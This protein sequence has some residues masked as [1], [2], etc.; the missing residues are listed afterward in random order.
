MLTSILPQPTQLI[1]GFSTMADGGMSLNGGF[2]N[3]QRYLAG[4]GLPPSQTV[5]AGLCHGDRI[6]V[7]SA[8]DGGQVM[9]EADGLITTDS[10][11]GL[12]MTAAD[13]LLVYL[14]DERTSR[15][16]LIHAGRRGLARD[17]LTKT[18]RQCRSLGS[19]LG[20]LHFSISP[21]ICQT[22]YEVS[23]VEAQPFRRW[24]EACL[25][26]GGKV[27]LDLRRVAV[28][29]LTGTGITTKQIT[30]DQTC[31]FESLRYFSYRRD[32]PASPQV[33]VGYLMRRS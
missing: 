29:Q 9:S 15:I 27:L 11:L 19:R 14:V 17:I 18:V 24:P 25:E 22:H 5:H 13:C 23:L 20:S 8:A 7:V 21:S 31:T 6:A 16:G 32:Q 1:A 4:Q 33:Q 10:N 26:R 12:A 28:A 2:A 30:I 3:R